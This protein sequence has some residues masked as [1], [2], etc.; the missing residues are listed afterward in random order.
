MTVV[1]IIGV[2]FLVFHHW[3]VTSPSF[4]QFPE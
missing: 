3:A 2:L 1:V 4:M